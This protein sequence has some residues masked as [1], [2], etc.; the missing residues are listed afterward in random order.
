MTKILNSHPDAFNTAAVKK[1]VKIFA[2]KQDDFS[3]WVKKSPAAMK[4]RIEQSQFNARPGQVIAIYDDKG[5]LASI[6]VGVNDPVQVFDLSVASDFIMKSVSDKILKET[7]FKLEGLK[8]SDLNNA[9]IGWAM[10]A[11]RFESYKSGKKKSV[12]PK[13]AW[14]DKADKKSVLAHI[15]S[16]CMIRTL[17]NIPANDMGPDELEKAARELA[18]A[19]DLTIKV[20][21]DKDLLKNNFPMVYEVGKGSPRRPRLIDMHWGNTKN[22]KITLVGKG[23]CFDTGGLDL[24]PS[25]AMYTMKKDMGGAA[26]VMGLA[27]LIIRHK[28]PIRLR[29]IIP[30]VENSVSGESYRPA[31]VINSRKGLTVEVGDTDAEGRL[32]LADA[33]ALACEDKPDFLIDFAT[34]TGAARVAT[35]MDIPSLFSNNEKLAF[36]LKDHAMSC[37]DPLWPMPLWQPYRKEMNSDIAD[38]CST[39]T[40]KAGAITAALFLESFVDL[41]TDWVHIDLSAWE[42]GGKPGRSKGGTEMGSRAV[43]DYLQHRFGKK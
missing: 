16:A 33:L 28:L 3:G 39:G 10:A 11:Y 41:K 23:V 14:P 38:I 12:C 9:C 4:R 36:T 29:V 42:G 7:T 35:G 26:H 24:K 32:I 34:L 18:S 43:F 20:T 27:L 40:G 15:E 13:L 25:S 8:G 6:A 17:I 22:P 31:D 37:Q 2:I 5:D 19:E 21:K 1:S 30:A